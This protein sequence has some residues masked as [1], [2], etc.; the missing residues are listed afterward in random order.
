MSESRELTRELSMRSRTS[1]KSD[2]SE[3][4]GKGPRRQHE[5]PWRHSGAV[6]D[7][8]HATA[9]VAVA[10]HDERSESAIDRS[11]GR[12]E[13]YLNYPERSRSNDGGLTGLRQRAREYSENIRRKRM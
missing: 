2:C 7:E 10:A 13:L 12:G 5:R 6:P 3:T 11:K 8:A 9:A 4:R 1:V